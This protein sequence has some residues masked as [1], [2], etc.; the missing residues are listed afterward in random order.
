MHERIEASDLAFA[1]NSLLINNFMTIAEK[2]GNDCLLIPLKGVSLL[3]ALYDEDCVRP[4]SDIDLLTDERSLPQLLK[5]LNELGYKLKS[6]SAFNRLKTKG[7]FDM[8]TDSPA[9]FALDVH[10]SLINKK[11]FRLTTGDFTAFAL[12]RIRQIPYK[13]QKISFL[14]PVDEWLYMAQHYCFHLFADDKWL[15]DLFMLQNSFSDAYIAEIQVVARQ[16]NLCRILTAAIRMM[17]HKYG[18][19][20]VKIPELVEG[21]HFIFDSLFRNPNKKYSATF[22]NRIIAAWWEFIFIDRSKARIKAFLRQL[23]PG[24]SLI[25]DIYAANNFFSILLLPIHP[26]ITLLSL[27]VFFSWIC[28]QYFLS[29]RRCVCRFRPLRF[30]ISRR[31]FWSVLP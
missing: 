28:G 31:C 25:S 29:V 14:S 24:I 18:T 9:F 30:R 27:A 17:K 5:I 21:K 23:F 6:P 13:E 2:C 20:A 19:D 15:R 22:F 10:I 12:S 1:R 26:V 11:F 7:K 16:F 8:L 3:I 4:V